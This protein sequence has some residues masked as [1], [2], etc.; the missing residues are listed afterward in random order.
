MDKKAMEQQRQ[1]GKVLEKQEKDVKKILILS[2]GTGR[3]EFLSN[4]GEIIKENDLTREEKQQMVM[5]GRL[6]PY[7]KTIYKKPDDSGIMESAFVA[8]PLIDLFSPHE[9]IIIGTSKSAWTSFFST[10][11]EENEQKKERISRLFA[12]EENGGKDLHTETLNEY[13]QKIQECYEQG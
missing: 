10:F 1:V 5:D 7:D 4:D 13:A 2:L 6:K 3:K 8:E 11:G 12:L 9:V